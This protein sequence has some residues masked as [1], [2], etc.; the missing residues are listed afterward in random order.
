MFRRR[1]E[2]LVTRLLKLNIF[3]VIKYVAQGVL[4]IYHFKKWKRRE[5]LFKE[6]PDAANSFE[7]SDKNN[8]GNNM[9]FLVA[10]IVGFFALSM[11][12]SSF[13]NV[14]GGRSS[15]FSP[16]YIHANGIDPKAL[17][18]GLKAYQCA[19]KKGL[20]KNKTL[21]IIDYSKPSTQKRM[22]VL[23]MEKRKVA[24]HE[25]VAHGQGSGNNK[26]NKFSNKPGSH[27]SSIGVFLTAADSYIGSHGL[28][29]RL[30]G[31]DKGFNDR[32][33]SRAIVVH[34]AP[35]VSNYYAK[36]HGRL[37]RSWGCPALEPSKTK[38]TI[39]KIKGGSVVVAYYPDNRWLDNSPY[40][41]C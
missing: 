36:I 26:A 27:Q 28:A 20:A 3:E 29:L 17:S 19:N 21:T 34:A 25:F 8:K 30:R 18:V 33:L 31:L 39:N 9:K 22:W 2:S 16:N 35:Y 12:C 6:N 37:G 23:D 4:P 14:N 5:Y 38:P 15:N 41:H 24:M 13:A 7:F 1:M 40:L 11:T 32:A 10:L